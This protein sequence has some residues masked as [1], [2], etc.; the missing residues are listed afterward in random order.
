MIYYLLFKFGAYDKKK[1]FTLLFLL[2]V[3]VVAISAENKR[4]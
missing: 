3:I 2:D 1:S 4:I